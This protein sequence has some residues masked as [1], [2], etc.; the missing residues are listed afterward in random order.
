MTGRPVAWTCS[1]T[2]KCS[3]GARR[4]NAVG[5]FRPHDGWRW[6]NGDEAVQGRLVGGCIE[7]LEFLKGT[8]HW[9]A[10]DWWDGRILFLETSE[11]RP[12]IDQ[13][14]SWLFN[15]GIQGVFDRLRGLVVGRARGYTDDQKRELDEM[16]RSTVIDEFGASHLV[17]A[18]DMDFGHTD[19]QWIL[20]IGVMAELD[21]RAS[22]FRLLEPAVE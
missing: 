18:T 14:R 17:I 12:S 5:E 19:P 13:V 3:S 10:E 11:E 6:L 9:P 15:Y 2:P 4:S 1:P 7:V 21:P 8:R 16:I 20:P 22:T